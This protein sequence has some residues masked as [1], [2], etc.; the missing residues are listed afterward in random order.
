MTALPAT[1]M[2]DSKVMLITG[3]SAVATRS[4]QLAISISS[5]SMMRP[6]SCR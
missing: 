3:G 6:N 4:A 2:T 1:G 5:P